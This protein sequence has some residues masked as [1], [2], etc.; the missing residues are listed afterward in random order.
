[1]LKVRDLAGQ[2]V[3]LWYLPHYMVEPQWPISGVPFIS[4]YAYCVDGRE[5][6]IPREDIIHFRWG[7][8]PNNPRRGW[9]RRAR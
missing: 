9:R 5:Y 6:Y 3:E 4:H 1:M 2:V 7:L 8:D